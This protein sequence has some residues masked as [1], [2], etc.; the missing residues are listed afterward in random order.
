MSQQ[1]IFAKIFNSQKFGQILVKR[2]SEDDEPNVTISYHTEQTG[3][4]NITIGFDKHDQSEAQ[5][6]TLFN[7]LDESKIDELLAQVPT[8]EYTLDELNGTKHQL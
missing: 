2:D 6:D 8:D 4:L 5:R 3:L 1:Y 7:R